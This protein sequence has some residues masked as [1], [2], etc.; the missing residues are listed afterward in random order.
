L[1]FSLSLGLVVRPL[2]LKLGRQFHH[3]ALILHPLNGVSPFLMQSKI[4]CVLR[5]CRL[6]DQKTLAIFADS[7]A[8]RDCRRC[9]AVGRY[10]SIKGRVNHVKA[11]GRIEDLK[12]VQHGSLAGAHAS[13]GLEESHWLCPIADRRRPDSS[14]EGML[15]GFSL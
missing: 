2:V 5:V 15:E 6:F 13:A 1:Q 11:Q 7:V 10:T 3:L 9:A 14:R 4:P 8:W 12:A